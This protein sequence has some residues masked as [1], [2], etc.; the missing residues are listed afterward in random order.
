MKLAKPKRKRNTFAAIVA[1]TAVI[2]ILIAP[3]CASV[4]ASKNCDLPSISVAATETGCHHGDAK[5]YPS[6]LNAAKKKACAGQESPVATL[7]STRSDQTISGKL[8]T[9]FTTLA[10]AKSTRFSVSADGNESRLDFYDVPL[11]QAQSSFTIAILR[12]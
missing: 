8:E 7:S 5:E 12:I 1:V 10:S 9:H 6:G 4:C 11:E 2:A 3:V